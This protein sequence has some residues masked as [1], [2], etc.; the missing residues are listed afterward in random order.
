[1]S[2]FIEEEPKTVLIYG[3]S[4]TWGFNFD[5]LS[6]FPFHQRW[7]NR[8]Q[9]S[10]NT[11]HPDKF[12]SIPEGL[13]GRTTVYDRS[14]EFEGAHNLNGRPTLPTILHTHKA[15]D[16]IVLALGTNDLV[17]TC[18]PH[19]EA[20]ERCV[21]GVRQLVKDTQSLLAGVGR[22]GSAKILV[23]GLPPLVS[24]EVNLS[25]DFPPNVG[26]IRNEANEK[27]RILCEE[28]K[29]DFLDI[30][31]V[32]TLNAKDGIHLNDEDQ[33]AMSII[34]TEKIIHLFV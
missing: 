8:V 4:N 30:S 26:E 31:P 2:Q 27:L 18:G 11:T 21:S 10:L 23:L 7:T 15:L 16:L 6:R 13:N 22:N 25:W 20:L 14:I 32:L 24:T 12:H 3:D 17:G 5:T 28:E 1:M 9:Q 34:F 33:V 29:V 19:D